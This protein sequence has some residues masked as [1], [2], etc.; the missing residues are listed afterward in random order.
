MFQFIT[1]KEGCMNQEK[2]ENDIKDK[3][4]KFTQIMISN[5]Y[6]KTKHVQIKKY[7][8]MFW[9]LKHD[10]IGLHFFTTKGVDF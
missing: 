2:H 4:Y 3:V 9:E 6:T 1:E 7:M 8:K 5:D 10:E